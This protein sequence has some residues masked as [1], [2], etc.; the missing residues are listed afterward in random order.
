MS[1][2]VEMKFHVANHDQLLERL[3]ALGALAHLSVAQVDT[4]LN[5]P[6]RDFSLSNEAFRLRQIGRD[7][8]VTYKG[9]RRAGPTKTRE[10]IEIA[11][12]PG[13]Q[14]FAQLSRLF[15][16][17]GFRR[18]ATV[19]K[20]RTAFQVDAFAHQIEIALDDVEGLGCFAEIETQAASEEFLPAAEQA[21]LAMAVQLSL[22]EVEPRSYLRMILQRDGSAQGDRDGATAAG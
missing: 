17:L 12:A 7:N 4:Y 6:A 2:E 9:P 22:T 21:V 3:A 16:I 1:F 20:V 19:R 10:E 11:F 8:R 13:D 5:H 18:V 14:G 15:E